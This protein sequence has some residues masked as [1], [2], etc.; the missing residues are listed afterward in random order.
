MLAWQSGIDN[1]YF[2]IKSK[3]KICW[4]GHKASTQTNKQCKNLC[5]QALSFKHSVYS[6]FILC[7]Q[8]HKIPHLIQTDGL[9]WL[10]KLI[11]AFTFCIFSGGHIYSSYLVTLSEILHLLTAAESTSW[12]PRAKKAALKGF[13]DSSLWFAL[14]HLSMGLILNFIYI[15]NN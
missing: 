4:L 3:L 15:P 7:F 10:Y 8:I 6:A 9:H 1:M 14:L 11:W 2:K 13:S 12:M 5:L